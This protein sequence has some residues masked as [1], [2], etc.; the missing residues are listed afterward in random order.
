[1]DIFEAVRTD[2]EHCR[3][4]LEQMEE[5]S[6]RGKARER[7]L[8]KLKTEMSLHQEAEEQV[9]YPTVLDEKDCREGGLEAIE[10]HNV[11]NLMLLDLEETAVDDERW[12]PKVIVLREFFE[13]H[14]EE[15]QEEIFDEVQDLLTEEEAED[16]GK[17][18]VAAKEKVRTGGKKRA[19]VVDDD[20]EDEEFEEEEDAEEEEYEVDEDEEDLDDV[21]DEEEEEEDEDEEE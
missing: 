1:M 7:L 15:E 18:F 3:E 17:E 2:H 10:E 20:D 4:L 16:M 12:R 6:P 13:H 21:D 5:S 9:F 8:T 19:V 14:I 11:M